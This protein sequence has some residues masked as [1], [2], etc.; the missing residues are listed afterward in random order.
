MNKENQFNGKLDWSVANVWNELLGLSKR[1]PPK[2]RDYLSPSDIGKS[3]WLRYQKMM[4]VPETNPFEDRVLRIFAAG[5]EF[6]HLMRNVFR[7]C[8]ILLKSEEWSVIPPTD[9]TLK[10]LGKYDVIAG[11]IANVEQAKKYCEEWN[12]SDF[13]AQRTIMMAEKL[14]E[15]YP[16]GMPKLLYEVKSINS[17]AFWNKKDYLQ[18]AYPH[19][20]LQ[21]YM[22]L[23]AENLPEGRV[24][25]ISKDD[26]MTAEFAVHLDDE[27]LKEI[28]Q[29]DMEE[30]TAFI[31]NKQEPPKPEYLSFNPR[32]KIRF[33]RN[34]EKYIIEGNWEANWEVSRSTY[35]T[36]LTGFKEVKEWEATLKSELKEKNDKIKA[37]YI[38]EQGL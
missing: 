21:C 24:L 10:I 6:H 11:G 38:E 25:Y 34:K 7:A 5:D 12:F 32:G 22:Y 36:L 26:L 20:T 4:G 37:E 13:V 16:V 30:M 23:K 28:V 1:Y 33:Q 18:Q 14:K 15:M 19:H 8:G 9:K 3:Y 27:K 17:M 35:F 31:D 29:K 2:K